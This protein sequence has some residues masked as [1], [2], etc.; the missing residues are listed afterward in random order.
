MIIYRAVQC[1]YIILSQI[2]NTTKI[3]SLLLPLSSH[4]P[5]MSNSLASSSPTSSKNS[6]LKYFPLCKTLLVKINPNCKIWFL[7]RIGREI[8]GRIKRR[9]WI[10]F[11]TFWILRREKEYACKIWFIREEKEKFSSKSL[12]SSNLDNQD[13]IAKWKFISRA[14][15]R[16][17]W[18]ISSRDFLEVE[19]LVNACSDPVQPLG[20]LSFLHYDHQSSEINL[21]HH[22]LQ[23]IC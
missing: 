4:S 1:L 22:Q 17:R 15:N 21:S 5:T 12:V 23:S 13:Y 10:F 18:T 7:T 20:N 8:E 16:K 2:S 3:Q 11:S 6:F 14:L 9:K 19:N